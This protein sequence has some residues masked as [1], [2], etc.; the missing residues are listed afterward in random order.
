MENALVDLKQSWLETIKERLLYQ[1]FQEVENGF[2]LIRVV[3]Q[4]GQ[5]ISING[6]VMQQ[7]GKE[8]E[9]KHSISLVGDGWIANE[10]ESNKEDFTQVVFET[11][12]D[13][14]LMVEYE[15]AFYWTEPYRLIEV[16]YQ[17]FK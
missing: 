4:P 1:G 16:L 3:R 10:D 5:T 17:I 14:E 15:E 7:P 11:Y 6:R 8:I 9:I 13:G 12:Q 2:E